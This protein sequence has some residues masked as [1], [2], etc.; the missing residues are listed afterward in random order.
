MK[1]NFGTGIFLFMAMFIIAMVSFVIFAHRQDVNLVHRDYYEK[2][3]DHTAQMNKDK[4]SATF[5]EQIHVTD[6]GSNVRITFD[7]GLAANIKNGRVLFFRPSD[8]NK[9][10]SY[11]VSCTGDTCRIEKKELIPGRYVVKI[12]WQTGQE[13]YEVDKPLIIK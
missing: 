2:G 1:F 13:D 4:R 5:K 6:D 8:H 9:D 10:I 7:S 3:V 11:P 12:T